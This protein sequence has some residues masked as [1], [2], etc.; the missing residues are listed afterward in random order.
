MEEDQY[1]NIVNRIANFIIDDIV[2][3][4][5]SY[6]KCSE[7]PEDIKCENNLFLINLNEI[8]K[9]YSK[10]ERSAL[11]IRHFLSSEFILQCG[12][13]EFFRSLDSI[14][15]MVSEKF[16]IIEINDKVFVYNNNAIVEKT[17]LNIPKLSAKKL[18][19][20]QL[21]SKM[22]S[23]F[24]KI[25]KNSSFS[26]M[27]YNNL[28]NYFVAYPDMTWL[29]NIFR[30]EPTEIRLGSIKK[31]LEDQNMSNLRHRCSGTPKMMEKILFISGGDE[32]IIQ[33]SYNLSIVE[34]VHAQ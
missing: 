20:S 3:T 26:H 1:G 10:M 23:I 31:Y 25:A 2:I 4:R 34:K 30:G 33:E 13:R 6:I 8:Y 21:R 14:L 16:W 17:L 32:N 18:N 22:K 28:V 12:Y 9:E 7:L 24:N 5:G 11:F 29:K 27:P 19:K 15:P